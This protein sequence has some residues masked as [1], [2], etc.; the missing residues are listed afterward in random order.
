MFSDGHWIILALFAIPVALGLATL[1]LSARLLR[2][3]VGS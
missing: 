2:R 3:F 1:W